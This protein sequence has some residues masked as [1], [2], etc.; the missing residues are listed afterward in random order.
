M[1][2]VKEIKRKTNN[3]KGHWIFLFNQHIII[4]VELF[5]K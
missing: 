2:D 3:N 4:S 1:Y 5:F